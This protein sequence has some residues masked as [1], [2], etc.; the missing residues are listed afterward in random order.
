MEPQTID[1]ISQWLTLLTLMAALVGTFLIVG[2]AAI[3]SLR[4]RTVRWDMLAYVLVILWSLPYGIRNYGPELTDAS[5]DLMMSLAAKR[6]A[7][8][9][10]IRSFLGD[11]LAGDSGDTAVTVPTVEFTATPLPTPSIDFA[12]TATAYFGDFPTA[13]PE[14]TATPTETPRPM[15]EPTWTDYQWQTNGTPAPTVFICQ[16]VEDVGKGCI[17]ATPE[18]GN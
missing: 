7:M 12:A 2:T 13:L 5:I 18:P 4:N 10:A 9:S 17:V 16:T 11:D 14:F 6:P 1:K 3:Q 15:I 8:E